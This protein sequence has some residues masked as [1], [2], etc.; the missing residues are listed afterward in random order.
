MAPP[1]TPAACDALVMFGITGDLAEKKLFGALY[2]LAAHGKTFV[3]TIGVA[4]RD[5][6]DEQLRRRARDV[7]SDSRDPDPVTLDELLGTLTYARGD[8]DDER[9]HTEL[10]TRL[11]GCANPLVYLGLPPALF[12]P[13]VDG[14]ADAG[15]ASRARLLVEK[16]FGD[17]LA[18]AVELSEQLNGHLD[19]E[20]V[21]R[22][23]HFLSKE[24]IQDLLVMRFANRLFRPLWSREHVAAVRITMSEDFGVDDRGDFYDRTGAVRDVLQNH[25]LQLIAVLA[26][27]SPDPDR[28]EDGLTDAR[29]GL[30]GSIRPLIADDVQLGQYEGYRDVDGVAGDSTTETFVRARLE[31]DD[32]RW[33]GVPWIVTTGKQLATTSTIAEFELR[34]VSRPSFIDDGTPIP[35]NRIRFELK[36]EEAVAVE[37]T[38]KGA[39]PFGIDLAPLEMRS[40]C[41]VAADVDAYARLFAA[42]ADGDRSLFASR[43]EVEAAW[44]VVDPIVGADLPIATYAPGSDPD[45]I[46]VHG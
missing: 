23:D 16:P 38:G 6:D 26:I 7:I 25:L 18:S 31:I 9:L 2:D 28:P 10:A 5:W 8:V 37:L 17:D 41:H 42:A 11:D 33:R 14:L 45:D 35:A 40:R 12:A 22:I 13:T 4:R 43:A 46:A 20:Q 36:P 29:A 32:D 1:T 30:L 27:D 24:S 44:R 3:P 21:F 15:I 34:E 39:S 19:E